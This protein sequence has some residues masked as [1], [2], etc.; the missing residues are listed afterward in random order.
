MYYRKET[1]T[2]TLNVRFRRYSVKTSLPES[3][4]NAGLLF[5]KEYFIMMTLKSFILKRSC[6][7]LYIITQDINSGKTK[8]LHSNKK[9]KVSLRVKVQ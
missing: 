8:C 5:R 6:Y 3:T 1:L 4:I 9:V 7:A 2:N